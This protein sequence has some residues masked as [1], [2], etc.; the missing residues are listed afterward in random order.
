[1]ELSREN[2]L[3]LKVF[4]NHLYEFKK[5]V[6]QMVLYTMSEKYRDY[7]M[8]RLQEQN[9]PF[10]ILPAGKNTINLFFGKQECIDVIKVLINGSL[11]QLSPEKDFMLGSLLGYD[12]CA[13][14]TRYCE[15]LRERNAS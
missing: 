1:M 7:V 5:G 4:S 15:R 2:I 10:W 13:Q 14:C 8:K 3:E 9:I 6:L 12:V 11:S